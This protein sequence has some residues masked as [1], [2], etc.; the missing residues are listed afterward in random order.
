MKI[1]EQI[2]RPEKI[3]A[4]FEDLK[5]LNLSERDLRNTIAEVLL[6]TEF[7]TKTIWPNKDKLP[8]DFIPEKVMFEAKNPGLGIRELHQKEINGQGVRVAIIDQ[9]LSS[10][11]GKFMPHSEYLS[12]I[13]D[14]KEFGDAAKESISMHG[15]AVASLLVGKSCGVAPGAEL[16]YRAVP[17]GRR[18]FNYKAEAL[19]DIIELNKTLP[20]ENKI[21]IV[22]CSIGY[23]EDEPEPGLERWIEAIKKAEEEG[24]IVSDVSNRTGIDSL[25]GGASGD[26]ENPENYDQWLR[27]SKNQRNEEFRKILSESGD[28]VELI[29]TRIKKMDIKEIAN[30][31]D[32]FLRQKIEDKLHEKE[33]EIIIPCD[34]RSMASRAG[35]DEYM[36]NGK[37]GLSWAVPY[38]SGLFALAFQVNPNLKKEEIAEAIKKTAIENTKGFKVVNPKRFIEVLKNS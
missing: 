1:F 11:D 5:G 35:A 19:L 25:G 34:Y 9:T 33:K 21:R 30:L 8:E 7:D 10:E 17:S 18:D 2:G 28:D 12:N 23:M 31:T 26:K 29:L 16:V 36:Y 38:L 4:E 22:S 13:V 37:G 27:V 20:L 6:T 24:I 3:V 32:D 15:P 14:Y